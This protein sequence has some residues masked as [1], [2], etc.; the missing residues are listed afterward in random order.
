MLHCTVGRRRFLQHLDRGCGQRR[1]V[2]Q[3]AFAGGEIAD[4]LA[5]ERQAPRALVDGDR[6]ADRVVDPG[7]VVVLKVLP[8]P[9]QSVMNRYADA[10][11][12]L[13]RADPRELQDM[14]RVDGAG[15]E[16]HFAFGIRTLDRAATLV[17]DRDRAAAVENYS[18]DLRFDDDLQ[19][20]R[21]SAG[22]R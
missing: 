19:V 5:G 20:G 13:G 16:D 4:D 15:G 18:V 11:Q 7:D 9:R 3:H 14:R 1:A 17:F 22:R 2:G 8:D 6:P 10:V 21:F 12:V